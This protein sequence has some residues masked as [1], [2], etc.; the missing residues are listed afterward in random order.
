[1]VNVSLQNSP[2]KVDDLYFMIVSSLKRGDSTLLLCKS[3]IES[4]AFLNTLFNDYKTRTKYFG[5]QRDDYAFFE[6]NLNGET[7]IRLIDQK[8]LESIVLEFEQS[9]T[10]LTEVKNYLESRNLTLV[11]MLQSDESQLLRYFLSYKFIFGEHIVFLYL[12]N[13]ENLYFDN[14]INLSELVDW[15]ESIT[16]SEESV[17]PGEL[18]FLPQDAPE[19]VEEKI[20]NPIRSETKSIN[21]VKHEPRVHFPSKVHSGQI[22]EPSLTARENLIYSM[23]KAR[24]FVSRLDIAV[25]V[26][27]ED[28]KTASDDAIDQVISRMRKKFVQAGYPKKYIT[29]KKGEGVLLDLDD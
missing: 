16:E 9:F 6:S 8:F 4:T 3:V 1:M 18:Q 21:K 26:W 28:G 14:V 29:S 25:S 24:T 20:V 23:L 7:D 19:I 27:G 10:E 12:S 11:V 2:T 22:V 15:V 5:R 17:L 13:K